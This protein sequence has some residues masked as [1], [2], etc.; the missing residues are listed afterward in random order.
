MKQPYLLVKGFRVWGR[1]DKTYYFFPIKPSVCP[2]LLCFEIGFLSVALPDQ[3]LILQ[4][5]DVGPRPRDL[6]ASAWHV[7]LDC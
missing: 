5:P 7:C 1:V 3:E 2:N 6:P 4:P